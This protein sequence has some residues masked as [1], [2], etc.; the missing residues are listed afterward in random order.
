VQVKISYSKPFTVNSREW[1]G[2]ASL[3]L[4]DDCCVL[5]SQRETRDSFD[6]RRCFL[7]AT[8]FGERAIPREIDRRPY[9][10]VVPGTGT[11]RRYVKGMLLPQWKFPLKIWGWRFCKHSKRRFSH[12]KIG[13]WTSPPSQCTVTG[14]DV[15]LPGIGA[16]NVDASGSFCTR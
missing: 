8:A 11:V 5:V 1:A 9:R 15:T 2:I 6:S 12:L 4:L 3:T 14:D 16:V 10:I 7:S 13:V